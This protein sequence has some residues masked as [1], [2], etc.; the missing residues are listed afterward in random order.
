MKRIDLISTWLLIIITSIVLMICLGGMTRLN[1][2]G[3]SIT[4]WSPIMGA[5]PPLS[6]DA[7]NEA[8][9]K[10]Q[11]IPQYQ[12]LKTVQ[13]LDDFKTIFY[14]EYFHRLLGRIIVMLVLI[15]GMVFWLTRRLSLLQFKRVLVGLTLI[16]GQAALGWFMVMS[17][18]SELVYVSHFRLAAHLIFGLMILAYWSW[19]FL[20]W[21]ASPAPIRFPRRRVI[22]TRR[23]VGL[24]VL[25]LFSQVFLGA[26]VAGLKAGLSY[27]TFPKMNGDW[28]PDEMRI[29]S[30]SLLNHPASVQ[31]LH[32][33]VAVILVLS[34]IFAVVQSEIKHLPW[35]MRSPGIVFLILLFFQFG[36]GVVTLLFQVPTS[37]AILHQ[38][39]GCLLVIS[40]TS[41]VYRV[42][43]DR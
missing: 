30:L 4:E 36:L 41:W 20:R 39:N 40:L 11:L 5:I 24:V 19:L 32:R 18:L 1:G 15:P 14:W 7:W 23:L 43:V 28:F 12:I 34:S 3:L 35:K 26:L 10:Y 9:R 13:S 17:G 29:F 22:R 33:W 38:L 6:L 16:L 2:A 21:N 8:F 37:F 31:F 42:S 27:N 25:F